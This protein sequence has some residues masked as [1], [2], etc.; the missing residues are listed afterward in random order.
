MTTGAPSRPHLHLP[1]EPSS[2]FPVATLTA[3][4]HL[5]IKPNKESHKQEAGARRGNTHTGYREDP[6]FQPPRPSGQILDF[7][8]Q[9]ITPTLFDLQKLY[10]HG[11][12]P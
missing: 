6:A 1:T 2:L 9:K 7:L 4:Q 8:A 11:A 3:S 10:P 12:C 5:H